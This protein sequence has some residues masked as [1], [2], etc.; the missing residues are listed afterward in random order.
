MPKSPRREASLFNS[1]NSDLARWRDG[2]VL[3]IIPAL[4]GLYPVFTG[5]LAF[6]TRGGWTVIDGTPARAAGVAAIALGLC[7]HFHAFWTT[8][9]KLEPYRTPATIAAAVVFLGALGIAM[10]TWLF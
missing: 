7:L 5:H 10:Y 8:E 2:V 9:E 1:G 4:A 6:S 3:A